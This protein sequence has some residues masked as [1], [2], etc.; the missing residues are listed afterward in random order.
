[1]SD[2][3]TRRQKALCA[4]LLNALLFYTLLPAFGWVWHD[5][6]P[7][8][9]HWFVSTTGPHQDAHEKRRLDFTSETASVSDDVQP[10]TTTIHAFNPGSFLQAL[11]LLAA[12]PTMLLPILSERLS[13]RWIAPP[14]FHRKIFLP[15]PDPPPKN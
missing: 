4:I 11:P 1:M 9:D 2:S 14:L 15:L 7:E 12:L 5:V 10:Q 13:L 6:V 8:H 3:I